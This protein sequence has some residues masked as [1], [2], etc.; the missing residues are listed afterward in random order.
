ML[1]AVSFSCYFLRYFLS[2]FFISITY[3]QYISFGSGLYFQGL[4]FSNLAKIHRI[5]RCVFEYQNQASII[6]AEERC[7]DLQFLYHR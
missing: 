6:A 7:K 5:R 4:V 1:E 2:A 3:Q